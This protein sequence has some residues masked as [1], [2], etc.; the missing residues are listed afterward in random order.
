METELWIPIPPELVWV[1]YE[2]TPRLDNPK[3]QQAKTVAEYCDRQMRE[4][5]DALTESFVELWLEANPNM[6]QVHGHA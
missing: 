5:L 3:I 1:P 2:T 6:A 4:A